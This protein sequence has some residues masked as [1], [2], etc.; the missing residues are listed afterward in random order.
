MTDSVSSN[1]KRDPTQFW[2]NTETVRQ[3]GPD[4]ILIRETVR[5][6]R[7][8]RLYTTRQSEETGL[9]AYILWDRQKKSELVYI[10]WDRQKRV[11]NSMP[12]HET[13]R[14]E[15]GTRTLIISMR[16]SRSDENLVPKHDTELRTAN[17]VS[18]KVLWDRIKKRPDSMPTHEYRQMIPNSS[19]SLGDTSEETRTQ[20]LIMRPSE[21][22]GLVYILWD[23]Q[24]RLGPQWL[25]IT[26]DRQTETRTRKSPMRH[27]RRWPDSIDR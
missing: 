21:E 20:C 18:S 2:K 12:N 7:T 8:Q 4:S 22:S 13:V 1:R 27:V 3:E 6:N 26:N 14:R 19:I 11:R 23:R 10:L 24:K 16:P 17:S 9:N 15:S 25:W 5:R